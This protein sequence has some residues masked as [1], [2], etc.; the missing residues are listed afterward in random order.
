L[1]C[2]ALPSEQFCPQADGKLSINHGK[3]EFPF[4]ADLG[5]SLPHSEKTTSRDLA[6]ISLLESNI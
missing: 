1:H 2:W 5:Y 4:D 3:K 6:I